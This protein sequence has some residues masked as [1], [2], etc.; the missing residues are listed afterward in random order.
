MRPPGLRQLRHL[1]LETS[2]ALVSPNCLPLMLPPLVSYSNCGL[3]WPRLDNRTATAIDQKISFKENW[4][5][6]EVPAVRLI[7]PKPEPLIVL[8]GSPKLTTLKRLKNS[9]RN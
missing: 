9:A 3:L 8:A 1:P 5:C 4:I 7:S 6:R 2:D